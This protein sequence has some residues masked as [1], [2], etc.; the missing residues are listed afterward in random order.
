M[1]TY[2]AIPPSKHQHCTDEAQKADTVLYNYNKIELL[3]VESCMAK[4]ARCYKVELFY[5]VVKSK[6]RHWFAVT[7]SFMP[8]GG[9]QTDFYYNEEIS[10]VLC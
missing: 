5:D 3:G 4:S 1:A 9:H 7:L 6:R 10:L 8:C 2:I